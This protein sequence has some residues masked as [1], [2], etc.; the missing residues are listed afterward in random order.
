[1]KK[2]VYILL[3]IAMTGQ[4][5]VWA[6]TL[7]R[8]RNIYST[9]GTLRVGGVVVININDASAMRFNFDLSSN[10]NSSVTSNP[11]VTITGFL[12]KVSANKTMD[13]ADS[14]N[15]TGRGQIDFTIAAAITAR[16]ANG[17][18][19][20]TGSRS[21]TFNGVT[22]RITV[23]GSIDPALLEGRTINSQNM[24]DFRMVIRASKDT[25]TIRR[26]ALKE[27]ETA[28]AALTEAEKQELIIDYL[29]KILGELSK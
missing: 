25:F 14:T 8:D 22:N 27:D 13:S 2:T 26:E 10:N 19:Q 12:P 18:Y 16:Q 11:D 29:Q 9:S 17:R 5:L 23:S 1:M 4:S 15:F 20:V 28:K 6:K 24:A 7:W 21:Y 3:I